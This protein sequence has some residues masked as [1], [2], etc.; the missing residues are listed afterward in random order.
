MQFIMEYI[1]CREHFSWLSQYTAATVIYFS[2]R[3]IH[4]QPKRARTM[5]IGVR[6][7]I[8]WFVIVLAIYFKAIQPYPHH[9]IL[10]TEN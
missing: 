8:T 7:I 10:M 2:Y 3:F 1:L 6:A 4:V 9:V 5:K